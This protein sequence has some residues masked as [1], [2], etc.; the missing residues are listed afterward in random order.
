MSEIKQLHEGRFLRL[1]RDRH[2]E[3]VSRVN[4][5]GAAFIVAVTDEDELLL[6][7]Q[8]R[9]PL[10]AR[11]IELPAGM[12]GDE[13]AFA[14]EGIE[15]SALRELEE[16]TGYRGSAARIL[17]SGPVA[18]GLT[19]EQLHLVEITGL[20]RVHDGGGVAGEDISVHRVPL[21]Q[22]HDWLEARRAAGL[23][24]EPRIY[25]GLYFVGRRG[26]Q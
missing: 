1:V 5:S 26:Q 22:V 20:Q 2:W 4:S 23:Q 14:G 15:E 17:L 11:S 18:A 21:A 16:E 3:Y 7:E 25:A 8:Y 10:Q 12:I 24:I 6:V 13:V 9:I 19:S